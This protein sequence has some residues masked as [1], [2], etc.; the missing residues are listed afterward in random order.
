MKS[1]TVGMKTIFINIKS[2][3]ESVQN[4]IIIAYTPLMVDLSPGIC[5]IGAA[6][7]YRHAE[8]G[9]IRTTSTGDLLK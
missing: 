4:L 5:E 1:G 9:P 6:L 3:L 8:V 2:S 7:V